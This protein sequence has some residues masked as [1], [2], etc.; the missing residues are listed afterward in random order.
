MKKADGT[1]NGQFNLTNEGSKNFSG[2][3]EVVCLT[4]SGNSAFVGTRVTSS[5]L[6]EYVGTEGGFW[7]QDNGEGAGAEDL[8]SLAWFGGDPGLAQE[9]CDGLTGIE[10]SA[11]PIDGG[12]IQVR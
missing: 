6:A 10:G 2:H 1:V 7:V 8:L 9:T 12:N 5:S 3:G 11:T 4:V